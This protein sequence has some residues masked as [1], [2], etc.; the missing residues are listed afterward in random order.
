[1]VPC[2]MRGCAAS[3]FQYFHAHSQGKAAINLWPQM[4]TAK[5]PKAGIHGHAS[6]AGDSHT[7]EGPGAPV[8]LHYACCGYANWRRKYEMLTT[9]PTVPGIAQPPATFTLSPGPKP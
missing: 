3:V 6:L 5:L 7:C 4:R 9:D 2:F 8:I 1:M